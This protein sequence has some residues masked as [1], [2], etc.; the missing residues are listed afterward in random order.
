MPDDQEKKFRPGMQADQHA[1]GLL[2][3]LVDPREPVAGSLADPGA[4]RPLGEDVAVCR[5]ARAH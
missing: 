3:Q 1:D 4:K 5:P 2:I